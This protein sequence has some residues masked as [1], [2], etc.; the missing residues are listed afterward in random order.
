[1]RIQPPYLTRKRLRTAGI[2]A[3]VSAAH[4]AVFAIIANST[5]P[6]P[7]LPLAPPINVELFRPAPPPPPPPPPSKPTPDPGGGAPAAPSRVHV[8]PPPPVDQP[9]ELPAPPVQAPEPALV[10]GMA[11]VAGP[12]PGMGQGGTGTGTGTGDGD[13]DGPGRGGTG[14]RFIRG[15]SSQE[16]LSVA[17]RL[18]RGV[19][20]PTGGATI[21]CVITLEERLDD[22]R[23]VD[24]RPPGFGFGEQ[25]LRAMRFF[26]YRPPLTRAGRP[27]EGQRVTLFVNVGRQ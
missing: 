1:M 19:R 6:V 25:A 11:P 18:P 7:M 22:C 26:Q 21:N 3:G 17:P 2:V 13:G 24:E 5:A 14:P 15:A 27:I 10:I 4:L 8:P 20:R 12:T 23:V 9:R 16:I